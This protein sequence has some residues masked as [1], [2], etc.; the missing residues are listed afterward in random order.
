MN[1]DIFFATVDYKQAS[2]VFSDLGI[3]TLPVIVHVKPSRK[4]DGSGRPFQLPGDMHSLERCP[5]HL[6]APAFPKTNQFLNNVRHRL[7]R[8]LTPPSALA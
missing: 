1:Q 6:N 3:R 8:R 7:E 4:R 5:R 2:G